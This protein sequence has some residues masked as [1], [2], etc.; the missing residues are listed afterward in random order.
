[1]P[2]ICSQQGNKSCA[3]YGKQNYGENHYNTY[4][5][6]DSVHAEIHACKKVAWKHRDRNKKKIKKHIISLLSVHLDQDPIL[7]CLDYVKD[8]YLV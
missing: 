7:V 8:V 6:N 3:F 5:T 4:S 2:R 1:M